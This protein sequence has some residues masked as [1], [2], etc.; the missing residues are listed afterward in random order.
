MMEE[1]S[2][3]KV[4]LS[5]LGVAILVVAV[6]GISFA[7]FSAT[8]VSDENTIST[9]TISMSYSEPTNG[10]ELIDALPMSDDKGKE[11]SGAVDGKNQTFE[12]T[13]STNTSAALNIPYEIS[14]TP[15]AITTTDTLGALTDKQVKVHLTKNGTEVVAPTLVD[16]LAATSVAGRNGSKTLYTTIDEHTGNDVINTSYVLRMWID[17][18]VSVDDITANGKSYEY[19]LKV[20]VDAAVAPLA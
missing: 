3:K 4:L 11:L 6:V 7:A 10:I 18:A 14:V 8:K 13:V 1:N 12:F 20:N 2:S 17:N 9:G 19:R 15:V 16:S 5:V